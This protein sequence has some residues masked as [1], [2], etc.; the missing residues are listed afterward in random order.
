MPPFGA[1]FCAPFI[2]FKFL[3]KALELK[4][5]SMPVSISPGPDKSSTT[6]LNRQM[7]DRIRS[8]KSTE[9]LV[10]YLTLH[11]H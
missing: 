7:N 8:Y 6:Q 11:Q 2:F 5:G 1:L 10:T 9:I 4:E 3:L